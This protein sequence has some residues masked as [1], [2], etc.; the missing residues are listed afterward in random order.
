MANPK[1]RDAEIFRAKDGRRYV[2]L[3]VGEESYFVS[4]LDLTKDG[5]EPKES[6]WGFEGAEDGAESLAHVQQYPW[7]GFPFNPELWK[8]GLQ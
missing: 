2:V 6:C 5:P 1:F 7:G 8:Q 4:C 3:A